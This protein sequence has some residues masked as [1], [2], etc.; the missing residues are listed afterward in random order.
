M[1]RDRG[2]QEEKMFEKLIEEFQKLPKKRIKEE[3]FISICGFPHREKVASNILAFFFDTSREHN[4]YDLF[5]RS[6]IES[7]GLSPE[8]YPSD[9]SSE[10][11]VYTKKGNYIDLLLRN[12]QINIV[13]ENKI[14]AWLYNDL[15][16]YYQTA[17]ENGKNKPLGIVLSYFPQEELN[18]NYKFITY[19]VF[20][21]SIKKNL[22]F[23]V[24]NANKRYLPF[25][26]DFIDN[27]EILDR[28]K[29]MDKEFVEFI[30]KNEKEAIDFSAKV[31][32]L[33]K[34][35]RNQVKAVNQICKER[36]IGKDVKIWEWRKLPS[37]FDAAVIDYYPNKNLD[38]ALDSILYL[39]KWSFKLWI[40]SN[41]TGNDIK[42]ENYVK[43][44][45]Q[46]GKIED[47]RFKFDTSF[48]FDEDIEIISN[49]IVDIINKL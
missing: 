41:K 38:I 26:I 6:L 40:R 3:S 39:N 12:D 19:D 31:E 46:K 34:E 32:E 2:M 35:L 20:F 43:K 21:N 37:L 8:D 14:Y 27:I 5:V 1:W 36:L 13:I 44:I 42:L 24:Q 22:G 9:F 4:L 29:N 45:D 47:G 15:D 18:P 23:Y 11:E 10:T 17:V 30:R 25:L 28:S 7:I 33:R 16:D 49:F 48:A